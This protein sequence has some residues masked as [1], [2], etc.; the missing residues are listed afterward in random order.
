MG[1]SWRAFVR[2]RTAVFFTFFFPVIII[3]IFGALV[4]TSA[5]GLFSR[6]QAY[7]LP[8][9]LAVVV[10]LTPLSRVGSTVARHRS[11][12]RFEKLA[13]TPL[14][15]YEW[16]A[17]HTLVNAIF[18][19]GASLVIV[20]VLLLLGAEFALSP[21]I[22]VYV[23]LGVAAFCGLGAVL[24]RLAGSQ[25]GVVA[26]SNAV[27]I[28][29]LFLAETFV[30]RE[31]LPASVLPLVDFLP[32]TYFSRGVRAATLAPTGGGYV[33]LVMLAAVALVFFVVG[34]YVIPWRE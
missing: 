21:W 12:N 28:P 23:F 4:E 8:G 15:R 27:G 7:Y 17:A 3:G 22:A 31:M 30:S 24:G 2:R 33:D 14:T 29:M 10:L 16:L 13:T 11:Y 34:G 5:A 19:G 25:D 1:A 9:Y 6:P 32:L 18:I 26:L 20:A